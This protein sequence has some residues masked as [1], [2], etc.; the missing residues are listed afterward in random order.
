MTSPSLTHGRGEGGSKNLGILIF[1]FFLKKYLFGL[2]FRDRVSLYSL[3]CPGTHSK[4]QAVHMSAVPHIGQKRASDLLEMEFLSLPHGCWE[5]NPG[6]LQ[7]QPVLLTAEP[8]FRPC[9]QKLW[10]LEIHGFCCN[11]PSPNQTLSH[12]VASIFNLLA[13][14]FFF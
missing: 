4:D 7:E 13:V 6:P 11:Q 1:F 3:G 14:F 9:K 8:S 10:W 5:R 12:L 2:I